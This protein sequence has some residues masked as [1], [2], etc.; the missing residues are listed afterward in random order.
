MSKFKQLTELLV[1]EKEERGKFSRILAETLHTFKAK[2]MDLY[3]GHTDALEYFAD[4]DKSSN[5]VERKVIGDTVPAKLKYTC[6]SITP[7][8]DM[9]LQKE[10]AN[11]RA[12]ASLEI[13]GK[14]FGTELPATFLLAMEARLAEVRQVLLETPNL[15]D[16]IEWE[17]DEKLGKN[18]YKS[19]TP[20]ERFKTKRIIV[21]F[22]LAQPTDK[23]PAQVEKL[24]EEKNV[25]R[26]TKT[27]FD[28]RLTTAKKSEM[29]A[30]LDNVIK[31]VKTARERANQVAVN[32]E[33][34][35]GTKIFAYILGE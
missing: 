30:R 16:G 35:I 5:I 11:Q 25:G 34:A 32:N 24:Q 15:P 7:Y 1:N 28:S 19:K 10:L 17:L 8:V 13:D 20:Q 14:T 6:D 27:L 23:H 4:E 33:A 2:I 22:V 31:A 26:Y 29:L 21:P 12:S 18:I 9:L 3:V